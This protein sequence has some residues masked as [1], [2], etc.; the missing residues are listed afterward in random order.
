VALAAFPGQRLAGRRARAVGHAVDSE[1][2]PSRYRAVCERC[3]RVM[4]LRAPRRGGIAAAMA[5]RSQ[6]ALW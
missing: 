4:L 5:S 6:E 2:V 1:A 3:V